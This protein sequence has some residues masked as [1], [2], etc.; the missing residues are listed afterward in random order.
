MFFEY[1]FPAFQKNL[2]HEPKLIS[3]KATVLRHFPASGRGIL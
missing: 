2:C 1:F 3:P